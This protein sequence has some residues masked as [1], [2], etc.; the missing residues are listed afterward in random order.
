MN[1]RFLI[2]VIF[3]ILI[4]CVINPISFGG[5][6]K[7]KQQQTFSKNLI[8]TWWRTY[9]GSN[10]DLGYSLQKTSD[11][12]FIIAG[13]TMFYNP[14]AT[15]GLLIKT[16]IN[17][18][19][20][21]ENI[22]GEPNPSTECIYSVKEC[23]EGGYIL[24]GFRYPPSEDYTCCWLIKT[25]VNGIHLWN[26]TYQFGGHT[27]GH[28]V[29]QTSDGG[30]ILIGIIYFNYPNWNSYCFVLKVDDSGNELW[31]RTYG[32][33]NSNYGRSIKHA[34][35]GGFIVLGL[36]YSDK[37]KNSYPWLLKLDSNAN[38][39]W[40]RTI[41]IENINYCNSWD[42]LESSDG[43]FVII[44]EADD[45]YNKLN[46]GLMIKTDDFGNEEWIRKYSNYIFYNTPYSFYQTDDG[47]F[48]ITGSTQNIFN[49]EWDLWLARTD[50][51][52]KLIWS[53]IL[54]LDRKNP[55]YN[56]SW[57]NSVL[58]D[59]DGGFI[60]LGSSNC[61]GSEIGDF[62][63]WL[64]K[65]DTKGNVVRNKAFLRYNWSNFL[66]IFPYLQRILNKLN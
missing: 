63:I 50:K 38:E 7:I 1:K 61:N 21:W 45:D 6:V 8:N 28:S 56:L 60:V 29:I 42:V 43:G 17:G 51:D 54:C 20:Q 3:F 35:D 40:N 34:I 30:F 5:N 46:Y 12:G 39:L 26:R 58:Q 36:N 31:N 55:E 18:I 37:H 48:I 11:E 9:G 33:I 65:T 13:E 62:D 49:Y 16:D 44:V 66:D 25:D 57:G 14:G 32:G 47:G 2:I 64:I 52:G 24:T 59:D 10:E 27:V 4:Y 15:E 41:F 19:K 23:I 22:L 53:K